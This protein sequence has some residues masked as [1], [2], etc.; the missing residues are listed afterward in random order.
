MKN[1]RKW[2]NSRSV[3]LTWSLSYLAVL[4][5]PV[6]LSAIVY[7]QSN[8]MLTDEIHLANDALLKQVREQMD[9]QIK[10]VDRLNFELMWNTKLRELVDQ[11]KY[12][13]YPQDYMY[14]LYNA[15]K[16]MALYKT[17]YTETDMFYIYLASRNTVLL[18][19]VYR[20]AEFAYKE[21]HGSGA[22][23]YEEWI[24]LLK[25]NK[26][27][28][29]LPIKRTTENGVSVEALA[30]V[31]TYD[32][33]DGKPAG[34]NVI[35]MD[36]SRILS[37]II[38]METFN[39]GHVIIADS[40]NKVLVS[41]SSSGSELP[42]RLPFETSPGKGSGMFFW[43]MGG[44]RY[45]VLS[46]P[47]AVS[48]LRYISMIPS[49]VYWKK[50]ELVRR[51]TLLSITASLLG[52][53]LLT[54]IFLRRTYNPIQRLVSAFSSKATQ[55][56]KGAN[57]WMFIQQAVD[58]T[59]DEMDHLTMR[60]K[61]QHYTL[62]SNFIMRMLKGKA[63]HGLPMEE[64]LSAFDI[65]LLLGGFGV[66]LF[67][68]EDLEVFLERVQGKTEGEKLQLLRF[69][70]TNVVE[71]LVN[72]KHRGYMAETDDAMVCLVSLADLPESEQKEDLLR[73]AHSAKAFLAD[74][75]SIYVTVSI[76]RIHSGLE[77]IP[78]AYQEA[79]D[80]MEYKL[81]MGKQEIL[82][83]EEI[84]RYSSRAETDSGYFYPLQLE[85][86]LMNYVKV[87]DF[88]SAQ[89]AL[90][91]ILRVNF[92]EQTVTVPVA[93]CLMLDLVGTLIKAIGELGGAAQENILIQNPKRIDRLSSSETLA[94]MRKQLEGLLTDAC[95]YA[96]TKR[97]QNLQENRQRVLDERMEE[98]AA[99][100]E[101]NYTDPGLNVSL[102]G[103]RFGMK[104]AYLSK[105]FKDQSG[106][107]LLETI[108]KKRIGRSKR[109]MTEEKLTVQEAAE[110]SGFNDVG[111]F[112]RT[113]KKI[114][115]I[116]PGKY[117]ETIEE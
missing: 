63:D 59:L 2:F 85:Q 106:E 6:I 13:V 101:S 72:V 111:T 31:S 33:E 90:D 84:E 16:D 99:F 108:N 69:I 66:L 107:G 3:L 92:A 14:D 109:L 34:A 9:K 112:I 78:Q 20:N 8:K 5:L 86:Q 52:G 113:F 60:M 40:S 15:T 117:K 7:M 70:V 11:H 25:R 65:R 36:K 95:A 45:E 18:P 115:G 58:R 1:K 64:A 67:Y 80:A 76:S 12:Q 62:R 103:Q 74:T 35:M 89:A 51:L 73:I 100:I 75:Y 61:R 81:V 43:E 116:T 44:Q 55:R 110:R 94:D 29:Y 56:E 42:D 104:P 102:L 68:L 30:Y 27:K 54:Y 46:I 87:G 28:G 48:D 32:Y 50:A 37:A 105:L 53:G 98:V 97:M 23:S 93:R 71:E 88:S 38:N 19:G 91:E 49:E 77:Q 57:E 47:S 114:E 41:S 82:P 79:L 39:K 17:A 26:Y 10:A 24:G 21:H 4:L 96:E 83:F 22:L